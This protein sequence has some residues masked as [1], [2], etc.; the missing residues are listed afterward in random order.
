MKQ[1]YQQPARGRSPAW[2]AVIVGGALVV[3]VGMVAGAFVL[4][5]GEGIG[6]GG[7]GRGT[8]RRGGRG[9]A[10]PSPAPRPDSFSFTGSHYSA[11][12]PAGWVQGDREKLA[13]DGSYIQ[14]TW[15][16]PDASE[17]LLIDESPG[18]PADP[19]RSVVKIA[20]YVRRADETIYAIHNGV[21]Y[22]GIV[23]SELDFRATSKPA[24]RADFFFNLD[25]DGF[26]VLASTSDLETAQRLLDPLVGSLQIR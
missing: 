16:S 5:S 1:P 25:N 8:N 6:T 24:E 3:A 15:T 26:A 20:G 10:G 12:L 9:V 13:S 2:A 22:G 21:E 18:A 23:G 14:D 4:T 17:E 19:A 11:T 7:H